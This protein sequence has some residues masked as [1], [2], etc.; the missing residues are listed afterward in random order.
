MQQ[1]WPGQEVPRM[2]GFCKASMPQAS[3]R[4]MDWTVST[5]FWQENGLFFARTEPEMYTHS[6]INTDNFAGNSKTW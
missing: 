4:Q 6:S 3:N 1:N 2:R 5:C